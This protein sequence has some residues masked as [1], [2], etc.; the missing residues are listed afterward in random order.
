MSFLGAKHMTD[1]KMEALLERIKTAQREFA[2]CQHRLSVPAVRVDAVRDRA[3]DVDYY[4]VCDKGH[5]SLP[6]T[7]PP[8]VVYCQACREDRFWR[9]QH[10]RYEQAKNE[11]AARS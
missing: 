7:T 5:A 6:Y 3:G 4:I 9:S 2:D 8:S 1:S 10:A 11:E